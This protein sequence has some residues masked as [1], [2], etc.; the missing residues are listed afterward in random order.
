[1]DQTRI[2]GDS[3]M[4]NLD[5]ISNQKINKY[6]GAMEALAKGD[7][8]TDE[9]KRF[10]REDIADAKLTCLKQLV[11]MDHAIQGKKTDLD[12]EMEEIYVYSIVNKLLEALT[13]IE[14]LN[15]Q[16]ATRDALIERLVEAGQELAD[17]LPY[18][19][20]EEIVNK[21]D[22]LCDEWEASKDG[23]AE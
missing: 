18:G 11:I 20:N 21:F 14:R 12:Y 10:T 1:M 17:E 8:M 6:A 7:E 15:S 5:N 4:T 23:G 16:L 2:F 19:V 13:E 3:E 22:A 9:L